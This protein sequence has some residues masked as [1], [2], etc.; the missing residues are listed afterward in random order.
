MSDLN[1]AEID[2]MKLPEGNLIDGID[3]ALSTEPSK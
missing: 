3:I 2:I 1:E